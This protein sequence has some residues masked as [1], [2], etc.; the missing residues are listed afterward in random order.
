MAH[1]FVVYKARLKT[2]EDSPGQLGLDSWG[3]MKKDGRWW[4]VSVSN[5]VV[6]PQRPLP[7]E[8]RK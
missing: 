7:E 2:P 6:T 8:L 1:C 4:I 5:D 3:L